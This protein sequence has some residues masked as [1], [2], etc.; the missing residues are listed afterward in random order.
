MFDCPM[1]MEEMKPP[2]KI[3]QCSNG[4]SFCDQCKD[5]PALRSCP[6][7]RVQFTGSNVTRNILAETLV[8]QLSSS[9]STSSA[10][11]SGWQPSGP[12]GQQLQQA[13]K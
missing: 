1:C 3:F 7:C 8:T 5:N 13:G 2:K 4:H 12:M 11:D 9:P 6:I 10:R